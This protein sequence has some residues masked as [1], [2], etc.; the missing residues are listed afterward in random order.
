M[1]KSLYVKSAPMLYSTQIESPLG[2]MIAISDHRAL[3]LLEFMDCKGLDREMHRLERRA[4]IKPGTTAILKSIAEEL[5][6]YFKGT[7]RSFKTPFEV[8]GTAFQKEVWTALQK[9]P[10][11]ATRSY[12]DLAASVGRPTAFRAAANA[13]AHNQLAIVIPCHR[14]INTGGALGGYGGKVER[15]AWLLAHEKKV[16]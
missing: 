4:P 1:D 2:P 3:C 13:N 14:V 12:A 9:I 15:K 10:Y 7:L 8:D 16:L 6:A 11:G 5:D